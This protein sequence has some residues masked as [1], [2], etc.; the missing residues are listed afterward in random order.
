[1]TDA[2]ILGIALE[3]IEFYSKSHRYER[4]KKRKAYILRDKGR[5]AREAQ[6][7]I[8]PDGALL[9]AHKLRNG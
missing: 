4:T 5:S 1:M 8:D 7:L 3:A 9:K 6:K 2:Q